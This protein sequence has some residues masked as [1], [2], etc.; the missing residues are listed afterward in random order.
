MWSF[1]WHTF[2]FDPVYNLL[3][4]VAGH[5]AGDVGVAIILF[6]VIAKFVLLP[7]SLKVA[8]GQH[9]MRLLEPELNRIKE[10]YKNDREMLGRKTMEAYRTAG[11]NPLSSIFLTVIQVMLMIA[12]FFAVSRGGGVHLPDVNTAL[13][14]SFVDVPQNLSM[15]FLGIFDITAKSVVLALLA[16]VTQYLHGVLSMPPLPPKTDAAP[17]FKEDLTRSMHLQMR[18]VMPLLMAVFAYSF[19]SAIALFMVVSNTASIFQ[20]FF[21][22]HKIPDRHKPLV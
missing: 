22:N 13:L 11:A 19:G 8:R 3:I 12:L 14:Y 5:T 21:I 16:G 7:L 20:E 4:F 17:N 10:Q 1:I 9:V 15:H 2:F 18:Y 6:T